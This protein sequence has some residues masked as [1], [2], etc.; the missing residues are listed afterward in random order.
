[1]SLPGVLS[2]SQPTP[3]PTPDPAVATQVSELIDE[4][5]SGTAV[6]TRTPAS[7]DQRLID[8]AINGGDT[9]TP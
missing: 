7:A 4:V 8:Q 6:P 1:M 9:N 2:P 5:V 3:T